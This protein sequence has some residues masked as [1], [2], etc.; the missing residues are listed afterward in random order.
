MP[1]LLF[2]NQEIAE[3]IIKEGSLVES[4]PSNKLQSHLKNIA[5]TFG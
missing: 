4:D 2:K 1:G 5:V 3:G